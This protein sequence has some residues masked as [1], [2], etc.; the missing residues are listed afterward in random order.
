[1]CEPHVVVQQHEN[2]AMNQQADYKRVARPLPQEVMNRG[3][4]SL[5][6]GNF[7]I[8]PRYTTCETMLSMDNQKGKPS[9]RQRRTCSVITA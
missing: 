9:M 3:S 1:M 2:Y 8:L 4:E 7:R 5:T 6:I